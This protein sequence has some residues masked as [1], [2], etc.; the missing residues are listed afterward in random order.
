MLSIE[1]LLKIYVIVKEL[2]HRFINLLANS[3]VLAVYHTILEREAS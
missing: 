2:I 3:K 1:T